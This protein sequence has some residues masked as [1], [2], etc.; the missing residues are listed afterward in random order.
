ME[1]SRAGETTGY[2]TTV[3]RQLFDPI[4]QRAEVYERSADGVSVTRYVRRRDGSVSETTIEVA[5][6]DGGDPHRDF[7][8]AWIK[9]PSAPSRV[10]TS[11]KSVRVVDLFS[12]SGGMSLGVLEAARALGLQFEPVLGVDVLGIAKTVYVQNFSPK[13]FESV[14]VEELFPGSLRDEPLASESR[15]KSQLGP[16]DILVGGPPCQ[17]HSNLNNK[18]RRRDDRNALFLRMARVAEILAPE[19]IIIENVPGVKHSHDGVFQKVWRHLRWLGYYVGAGLFHADRFGVPQTRSRM[20]LIAS[21]KRQVSVE[22]FYSHYSTPPRPAEWALDDLLHADP[23]NPFDRPRQPRGITQRRIDYLF[24]NNLYNLPDEERPM[25]H[26]DKPHTYPS[27]YGRM[28]PDAPAPTITT[29]FMTMGQGRF[30]HPYARRT[31]TPH[32]AARLQFFPDWFRFGTLSG[33][34]YVT[35]IGNAVPSRLSYVVALELLR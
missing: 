19:H 18:T 20:L 12:G 35:L 30:V 1:S 13:R 25:C 27:V 6:N 31:L 32:E 16:I 3:Q 33:Q 22:D 4:E 5:V 26:R 28:R 21:R 29:G 23:A 17:G 34:E 14:P 24:D 8:A 10:E 2:R 11:A 7:D 15:L 9:A